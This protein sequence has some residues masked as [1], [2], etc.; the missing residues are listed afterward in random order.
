ME[1][2]SIQIP[3]QSLDA[4]LA[5]KPDGAQRKTQFGGDLSVGSR[6]RFEKKKLHKPTALRTK[7]SHRFAQQLLFLRLLHQG[8][9]DWRWLR[10]R[11]VRLR[12]AGDQAL[13]LALIAEALVGVHPHEPFGHRR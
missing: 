5:R 10:I 13:L 1:S 4:L 6:R 12:V 11:Q 8:F 2:Q 7:T 9:R 3:P